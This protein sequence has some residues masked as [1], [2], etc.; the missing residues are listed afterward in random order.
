VHRIVECICIIFKK[1]FI[2]ATHTTSW[3]RKILGN[4]KQR[5][6][7]VKYASIGVGITII[8]TAL[9]FGHRWYVMHREREAQALLAEYIHKTQ[10]DSSLSLPDAAA[11]FQEG[12]QKQSGSYLAPYFLVFQAN[13]LVK[14]GKID[15]AIEIIEKALAGMSQDNPLV[16]L[17]EVKRALMQLDSTQAPIKEAG[18]KRLTELA[19]DTNNTYA[20]MALFYLG[21]YYWSI[22]DLNQAKMVWE[23][24]IN[25]QLKEQLVS[26]SPWAQLA[27]IKLQQITA[28]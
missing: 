11:L 28:Q 4:E 9:F 14:E 19:R 6:M 20:D 23:D 12:A 15:E 10:T 7:Y 21:N 27:Q 18:L 3:Y 22:N 26:P 5:E 17:F 2:M 25:I 24:L 13:A 1:G 8:A 16:P